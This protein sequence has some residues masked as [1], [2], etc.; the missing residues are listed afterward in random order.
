MFVLRLFFG[1]EEEIEKNLKKKRTERRE[2]D[3]G[4]RDESFLM[5]R[6]ESLAFVFLQLSIFVFNFH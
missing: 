1:R 3:E 5:K 6:P 4:R 2:K